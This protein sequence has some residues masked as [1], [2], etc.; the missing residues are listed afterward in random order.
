MIDI[1]QD[2]LALLG[3]AAIDKDGALL[4]M[5]H[6]YHPWESTSGKND[7][8]VSNRSIAI[9]ELI[10]HHHSPD[11]PPFFIAWSI[12]EPKYSELTTVTHVALKGPSLMILRA[13]GRASGNTGIIEVSPSKF[14][15][16]FCSAKA[17]RRPSLDL[18]PHDPVGIKTLRQWH[19]YDDAMDML[20]CIQ[21]LVLLSPLDL[22]FEKTYF[23]KCIPISCAAFSLPASRIDVTLDHCR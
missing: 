22:I 21:C 16:G 18:L 4:H 14:F 8:R 17:R 7:I 13:L 6:L 19:L 20:R 1:P 23:S 2:F 10:H 3:N 12:T 5:V 15:H 11:D 9:R